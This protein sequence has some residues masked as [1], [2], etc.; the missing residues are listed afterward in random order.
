[1]SNDFHYFLKRY[2]GKCVWLQMLV[3]W[4]PLPA[5]DVIKDCPYNY[6]YVFIR[7]NSIP[8]MST[9]ADIV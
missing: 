3:C 4:Y 8:F 7:S 9:D 1:M 6:I 2:N 5:Y